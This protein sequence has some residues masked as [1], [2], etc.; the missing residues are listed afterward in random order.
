[1]IRVVKVTESK[2]LSR[3]TRRSA[4]ARQERSVGANGEHSVLA[5]GHHY[6]G[7]LSGSGTVRVEGVFEGEINLQGALVVSESGKVAC[8][9]VRA[10]A[11]VVAGNVKAN[12]FAQRVEIRSTGRVWG[13]IETVEF[14][15]EDGAYLH[16]TITLLEQ[17]ALDLDADR[18]AELA[19][20][21]ADFPQ[22]AEAGD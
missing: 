11:I 19:I 1:M 16:G 3:S 2:R 14:Q 13:D 17:I 15:T 7:R 22:G 20:P 10:Q 18:G 12:L 8:T 5:D 4:C 21:V 6:H 9:R